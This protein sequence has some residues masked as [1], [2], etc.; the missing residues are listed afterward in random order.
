LSELFVSVM[1][2]LRS[3]ADCGVNF[4]PTL[5]EV[6]GVRTVLDVTGLTVAVSSEK[7]AV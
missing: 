6:P 4:T 1:F 3:P 2:A 5:P 7:S